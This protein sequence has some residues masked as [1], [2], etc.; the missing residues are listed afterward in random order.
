MRSR[1]A[2]T[3]VVLTLVGAMIAGSVLE[4]GRAHV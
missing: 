4:I 1:I 3:A 2:T